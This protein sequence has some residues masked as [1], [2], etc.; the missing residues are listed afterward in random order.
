MRKGADI[1]NPNTGQLLEIDLWVPNY[2][3]CFEFQ[4]PPSP[5]PLSS[6]SLLSLLFLSLPLIFSNFL[7][8]C[9]GLIYYC[10]M[11]TTISRHGIRISPFL[12]L[13]RR[14]VSP[15]ISPSSLSLL[16]PSLPSFS[17]FPYLSYHF[18]YKDSGERS[19]N[20]GEGPYSRPRA[21]L[22]ARRTR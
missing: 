7:L 11:T 9:L 15:T 6:P 3:I 19:S 5:L 4:V 18:F 8:F 16:S 21:L 17:P 1:I 13:D 12:P 10:R 14:T 22:V 20:E 2:N